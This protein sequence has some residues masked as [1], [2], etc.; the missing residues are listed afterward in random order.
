MPPGASPG[1]DCTDVGTPLNGPYTLG[2]AFPTYVGAS[3][4][5]NVG[6]WR[7]QFYNYYVHDGILSTLGHRHDWEG[8][9]VKWQQDP[10]GD[11]WHR[12]GAIYNKHCMHDHY[13]WDQL[14]T[15]DV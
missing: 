13:T 5:S 3:W 14:N 2:N 7:M 1:E 11:W 10:E 15:V 12:A 6:E 8:I 4:C 9:V